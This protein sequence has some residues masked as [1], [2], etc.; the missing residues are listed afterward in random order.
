MGAATQ[1]TDL[2]DLRTDLIERVREATGETATNTIADRYINI[3]LHDMHINPGHNFSW[4]IRRGYLLTHAPYTTGTVSIT[5]SARTTVTGASTEWNT[6]VT[7]MG[8]NNA[9]AGGKMVFSGSDEVYE[10]SAVGSDTSITLVNRWTGAALSGASYVYYEDEYALASDFG[11]PV[12]MRNFSMDYHIPLIGQMKFRQLYPRNSRRSKPRI[13]TL[14]D[15]GFSGSTAPRPR[16][17]LHP[18][19]DDEY[20]IPYSYITTNLAVSSTGTEQ[21][22]LTATSDEPIVP[23]RFRHA[24]VFH[25]LYHW[26]RDMK[27]DTRSQ[28]AKGEYVDIIKRVGGDIQ[29]GADRPQFVVRGYGRKR[30]LG[31]FDVGGRFD[32][33]RDR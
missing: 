26:Y 25:A 13:A 19:P 22:Q 32:D 27:D 31:R 24:I 17:V 1:V 6:A 23:L 7:G 30:R 3:A 8:F 18:A 10:V 33:L 5:A 4:A 16:V 9:R 12:D 28:E 2:T 21:A 11:R 20:S 29:I 14:I 15:I